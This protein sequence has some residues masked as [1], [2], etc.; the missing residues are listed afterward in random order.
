MNFRRITGPV[1]GA[2]AGVGAIGA[3]LAHAQDEDLGDSIANSV[4]GS[5]S[6]IA[7]NS[8]GTVT[9]G[10]SVEHNELSLGEQEGLAIADASG[11]NNNVSFVS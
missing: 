4:T 8:G 9:G 10:T 11:G 7:T 3:E 1:A 5:V 6:S 2:T